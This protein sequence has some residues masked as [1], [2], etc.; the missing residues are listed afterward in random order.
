V[1]A[2]VSALNKTRGALHP[3][4]HLASDAHEQ[5]SVLKA[6]GSCLASTLLGREFRGPLCASWSLERLCAIRHKQSVGS[7]T[8]L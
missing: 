1:P 4:Q 5:S 3:M 8:N 6:A 2:L 7:D